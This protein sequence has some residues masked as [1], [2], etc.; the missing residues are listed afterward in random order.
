MSNLQGPEHPFLIGAYV[1]GRLDAEEND[2][3]RH[4]LEH[5][6]VCQQELAELESVKRALDGV[7]AELVLEQL[8]L[9]VDDVSP[10]QDELLLQRTLRQ[11]RAESGGDR[12]RSRLV[13]V[14]AA[15]VLLGLGAGVGI[16]VDRAT[17]PPP[18][19]ATTISYAPLGQAT[20]PR[21]GIGL[22]AASADAAGWTRLQVRV[23]GA[24]AGATCRLYAVGRD[25]RREVAGSWVIAQPGSGARPVEAAVAIPRGDISRLELESADGRHWVTVTL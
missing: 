8:A 6:A 14:A 22:T 3:A 12:R 17:A 4:H 24:P 2:T 23:S 20:D 25:G 7:P 21:T 19:S 5:C 11:V 18:S 9:D 16:A 1:M 15:V 13:A 10:V